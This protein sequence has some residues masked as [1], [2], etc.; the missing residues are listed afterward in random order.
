[1]SEWVILAAV[2]LVMLAVSSVRVARRYGA[3]AMLLFVALGLFV[4]EAGPVG[5]VFED[6]ALAYEMGLVALA[7]IVFAG[8]FETEK[9]S[10]RAALVPSMS[11]AT[12]GVFVKMAVVGGALVAFTDM[13]IGEALL[14]GAI[15]APTDA[16]AV[17]NVLKGQGL[18][19]RLAGMLEAESGTND[20]VSIYLTIA[21]TSLVVTGTMEAS[22]M[23]VGMAVQLGLGTVYGVLGGHGLRVLVNHM[24]PKD[25]PGLYPV[26]ALAGGLGVYALSTLLGGNGFLAAYLAGHF[27][28]RGRVLFRR[29]V[30]HLLDSA[31]WFAQISLFLVLGLL[32]SPALVGAILPLALGTTLTVLLARPIAVIAAVAPLRLFGIRFERAEI[33]LLSWGGLKGAVPIILAMVPLLAGHEGGE[34]IFHVVFV[35]VLLATTLQGLTLIPLARYL[36]LLEPPRPVPPVSL[37]LGGIAP[38]GSAIVDVAIDLAHPACG[39]SVAELDL[40]PTVALAAI[41]RDGRIVA[42]RGPVIL[43]DGDHV[44]VLIPDETD[45]ETV[46]AVSRL[47]GRTGPPR[48]PVEAQLASG[49]TPASTSSP[50]SVP[51]HASAGAPEPASQTASPAADDDLGDGTTLVG[52]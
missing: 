12:V 22:D 48:R 52:P 39:V 40:S 14:L 5:F 6:F 16:A 33:A 35:V 28:G 21:M 38:P 10:L 45:A 19:P 51:S 26:L 49:A 31:A 50:D 27:M 41:V 34:R 7:L 46:A 9:D 8:G 1:M 20:P 30:E 3:P 15:V 47:R 17:F 37:E 43:S 32:A 23:V 18:R 44:F 25:S 24:P 4:G 13:H 36:D 29:E 42:P 11:L 2:I